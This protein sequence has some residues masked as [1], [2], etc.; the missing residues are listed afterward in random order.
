M[1]YVFYLRVSTNEQD[2]RTQEEIC[3]RHL[4]AKGDTQFKHVVFWD[5][6]SSRRSFD[7]RE[8]LQ[9]A[10]ASLKSGDILVGLRLDRF[11]R[12]LYE[13]TQIIEILRLKKVEIILIDQPGISNKVLLGLYAGMAEEEVKMIR[14]RIKEKLA[15]KSSRNERISGIIPYGYQL[16][17]VK[18]VAVRHGDTVKHK[19]GVL[20]PLESEQRVIDYMK[21]LHCQQ[22]SLRGIAKDMA[23]KG[24]KNR[25]NRPFQIMSIYRILKREL[26]NH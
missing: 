14:K 7:K 5:K 18:T 10:L 15:V 1:K 17:P 22:L 19:L 12:N 16:D 8:G 21:K 13:T 3:L 24:Y 20:I 25:N 4:K 11:A 2:L 26:P 23:L 6:I 9:K